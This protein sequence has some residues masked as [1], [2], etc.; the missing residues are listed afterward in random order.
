MLR[1]EL[2]RTLTVV[3]AWAMHSVVKPAAASAKMRLEIQYFIGLSRHI[4]FKKL[5]ETELR[6][7]VRPAVCPIYT[8]SRR[9]ARHAFGH[10]KAVTCSPR[11]PEPFR[12]CH[13]RAMAPVGGIEQPSSGCGCG[14]SGLVGRLGQAG[15]PSYAFVS[16]AELGQV[17]R[18]VD[19]AAIEDYRFGQL[20]LDAIEIGTP[21]CLPFGNYHQCIGAVKRLIRV[22]DQRQ[23][24][25]FAADSPGFRHGLGIERTNLRPGC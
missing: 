22:L 14:A 25:A 21:E 20:G 13:A 10:K 17:A 3:P 9:N 15:A 24:I 7:Q 23:V 18:I 16:E 12:R 11:S 4:V 6:M 8:N 1:P 5:L 19:V 2:S